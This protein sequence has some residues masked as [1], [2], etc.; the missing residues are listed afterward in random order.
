[1]LV[2]YRV[3]GQ[4]VHRLGVRL[5]GIYL[6]DKKPDQAMLVLEKAM[7]NFSAAPESYQTEDRK[8][9]IA[10][11]TARAMSQKGRGSDAIAFLE[12]VPA[13]PDVNRLRADI[14]WRA[15]FWDDAAAALGDII[16]DEDISL[17]RPLSPEHA[18]LILQ[19]AV[20]LNLAG[21]R[22]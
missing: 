20:A 22:V 12:T 10:L 8:R 17:T 18:S 1:N 7:K 15:S 19:R 6:I 9:E 3:S 4:E 11:L 2:D 16:L 5:A 21:D 14:A 13:H